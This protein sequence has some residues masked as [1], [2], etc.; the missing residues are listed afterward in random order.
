M[1]TGQDQEQ[2]A[3]GYRPPTAVDAPAVSIVIP[4]HNN[5]SLLLECLESVRGLDYPREKLEIIVVDNGSVDRTHD[6]ITTRYPHVRLIR[7]E[8]NTGFAPACDRGAQEATGQYVAFLNNDAVV[9][10]DWLTALLNA[11]SAGGE[12]TVCVASRI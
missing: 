5:V 4:T 12:G 9:S 8:G 6:V 11:L 2:P 1:T 10:P 7:L 3:T